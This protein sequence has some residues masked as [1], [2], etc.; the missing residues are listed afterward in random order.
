M[1]TTVTGLL[2]ALLRPGDETAAGSRDRRVAGDAAM[3]TTATTG[4]RAGRARSTRS[5][6]RAGVP[7]VSL[8]CR[9]RL[10]GSARL[11]RTVGRAVLHRGHGTIPRLL[12]CRTNRTARRQRRA[13]CGRANAFRRHGRCGSVLL[14][15]TSGRR[16]FLAARR[17]SRSPSWSR[18]SVKRVPLDDR[19]CGDVH[20]YDGRTN[21]RARDRT[22][23]ARVTTVFV[24]HEKTGEK[25]IIRRA[26]NIFY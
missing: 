17:F 22:T 1:R 5:P 9:V 12:R 24:R 18:P 15:R 19:S 25:K 7:A 6:A 14:A 21:C 4:V 13:R 10:C 16:S 11:V 26:K 8:F 3:V 20:L 2:A 23:R